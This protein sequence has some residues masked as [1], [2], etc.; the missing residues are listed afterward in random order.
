MT[1][2]KWIQPQERANAKTLRLALRWM[3]ILATALI[4]APPGGARPGGFE[5]GLILAFAASNIALTY[6][7]EFLFR[8]RRLEYVVVVSDTFL[9][10]LG[11]FRARMEGSDLALAFFLNLMLAALGTDLKRIMAGATL[12]SG[13]YLYMTRFHGGPVVDLTPLLLRIPFLYTAALYYG[14]LVHQGR[15]EQARAGL[16]ERERLELKT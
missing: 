9:V 10:S 2:R 13:F 16:I 3:L 5:V 1:R 7:P 4:L 8:S 14:H 12:V 15:L 11:L 6:L